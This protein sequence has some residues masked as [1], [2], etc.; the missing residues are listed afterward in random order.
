MLGMGNEGHFTYLTSQEK[1]MKNLCI[2]NFLKLI[3][4]PHEIINGHY[5]LCRLFQFISHFLSHFSVIYENKYGVSTLM[6]VCILGF[7]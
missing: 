5:L 6:H 4:L 7:I 1:I 3:L 2:L